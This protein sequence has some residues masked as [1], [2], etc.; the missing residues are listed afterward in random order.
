MRTHKRVDQRRFTRT[1]RP[2]NTDDLSLGDTE[3]DAF[4]RLE[5]AVMHG[6]VVD[7]QCQFTH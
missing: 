6:Q 3:I 1:V 5:L 2:E 7:V 4:K